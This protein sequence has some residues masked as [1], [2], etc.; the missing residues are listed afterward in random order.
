MIVVEA[1][2]LIDARWHEKMNEV[3]VCFIPHDEAISR[4]LRRNPNL[5]R[6][7]AEKLFANQISNRERLSYANVAFCSLWEREVTQ[8]QVYKAWDSLSKRLKL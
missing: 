6:E 1:A 8:K 7:E 4:A 5:T 3:W 2:L